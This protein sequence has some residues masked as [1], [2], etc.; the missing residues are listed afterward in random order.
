MGSSCGSFTRVRRLI[1]PLA[2]GLIAAGSTTSAL[3]QDSGPGIAI[4][5]VAQGWN[6]VRVD[7]G[8]GDPARTELR[9]LLPGGRAIVV[10][11][12][13]ALQ[14][15]LVWDRKVSFR[16]VHPGR[17]TLQVIATNASGTSITN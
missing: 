12:S 13:S 11:R 6:K 10:D 2:V 5:S 9:V 1:L 15:T 4:G 8:V 7:F 17:Y 16:H 3:A 14:G